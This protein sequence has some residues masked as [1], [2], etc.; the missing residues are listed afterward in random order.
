MVM[1]LPPSTKVALVLTVRLL[2]VVATARV[3]VC[4][5][6]ITASSASAGMQRQ[7]HVAGLFQEPVCTEVLT[8]ANRNWALKHRIKQMEAGSKNLGL[9]TYDVLVDS[10]V[11]AKVNYASMLF[12]LCLYYT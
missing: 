9:I 7:F 12:I 10:T 1:L 11:Q 6:A 5:A 2:M 3:T 4:P 8:W